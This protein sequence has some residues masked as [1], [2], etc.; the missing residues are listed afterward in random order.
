MGAGE[1]LAQH[2]HD[3]DHAGDGRLEAEQHAAL[4]GERP[5]LLAVTREQLLVCRH[6]VATGF[7]RAPHV[8]AGGVDAADQLDDQLRALEDVVEVTARARQHP[9]DLGPAP[10]QAL[11]RVGTLGEQLIEGA[12]DGAVAEQ[13]DAKGG[14]RPQTSRAWRSSSVSRRTTTRAVPSLA[15][16]TGAR[17]TPL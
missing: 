8:L 13:A 14:H 5:Q 17:G 6:D 4:A 2:P 16:I 7:E 12:A 11:E 15:K 3:R 10:A 1:R 9:D